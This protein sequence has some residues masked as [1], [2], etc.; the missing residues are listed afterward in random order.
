M[1]SSKTTKDNK[2][3]TLSPISKLKIFTLIR[4][5]YGGGHDAGASQ[6]QA[7]RRNLFEEE[8]EIDVNAAQNVYQPSYEPTY[9]Q[10][11]PEPYQQQ[12]YKPSYESKESTF[13]QESNIISDLNKMKL[14]DGASSGLDDFFEREDPKSAAFRVFNPVKVSGHIK[15]TVSGIDADG[16]FEEARRF[17]EFFALKEALTARWPGIYIPAIPE[18]KL[19]GNKDDKFIEERRAMLERFMKELAKFDYLIQSREFRVFIRERGD[20]EK[21]LTSMIK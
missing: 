9:Q 14:Q 5:S 15:Y 19:M 16:Q 7:Q 4:S 21:I 10:Q 2:P 3:L 18:K 12:E 17:S 20:I 11:Q 13:A 1:G 6:A 8:V